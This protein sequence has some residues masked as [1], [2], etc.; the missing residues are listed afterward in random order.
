MKKLATA[1]LR[2]GYQVLGIAFEAADVWLAR[3]LASP[4]LAPA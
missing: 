3:H 2:E 1:P 4:K